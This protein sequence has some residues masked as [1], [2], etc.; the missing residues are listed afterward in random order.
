M[1]NIVI[2]FIFICAYICFGGCINYI[3]APIKKYEYS[4]GITEFE[5][6]LKKFANAN[7]GMTL[8]ISRRDSTNDNSARDMIVELKGYSRDIVYDLAYVET[9]HN[10]ITEIDL[11][12]IH[13]KIRKTGGYKFKDVGVKELFNDFKNDFLMRLEKDQDIILKPETFNF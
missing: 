13:D 5:N 2:C 6:G 7:P 12:G 1:R 11:I 3:S 4:G 9:L 10:E 8:T